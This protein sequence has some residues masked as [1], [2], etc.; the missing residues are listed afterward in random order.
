MDVAGRTTTLFMDTGATYS[1]LTSFSGPFSQDSCKV[2]EVSGK[3]I[4]KPFNPLMLP[5]G[6]LH[7]FPLLP[8]YAG[9]P[10]APSG[11]RHIIQ[12]RS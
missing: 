2:M 3:L 10:L 9:V 11:K 12:T 6:R 8:V 7:L 1:V 5:M 4:T